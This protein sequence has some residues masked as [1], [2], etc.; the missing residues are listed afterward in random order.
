MS[1]RV[2]IVGGGLAGSEAAW[3]I[4]E[5]GFGVDLY[6]MRPVRGTDAHRTERL[7]ELVCSNS[8]RNA[9][10]ETA[11]GCLK[12]EMRRLGSLVLAVADRTTVPAGAC[13]AVDRNLFAEGVTRA[14][15]EHPNVRLHRRELEAI[16]DGVAILATGP[17]TSPALSSALERFFGEA[18][19]YFYDAIAPIVAS[20]SIDM[21]IAYKASRY[22][23]GGD[24]YV[25]CPMTRDEYYAFVDAVLAAEKVPAKQFE[26]T[27]YFEGCMPIEEMA[28][29]GRD[30]LAFGPMRPVGLIDPRTGARPF[31]VVQLRQDDVE[32]RLFNMVG[33]QTKMTYPE[34]RR[35]FRMIPGL[36]AAE[37]VRLGS[38]HRNTFVDS[39]NVLM[40]TLQLRA[41]RTTFLAGQIIGVEGYVESAAAGLLAGINAARLLAGAPLVSPPATTA[42]GSLLAYVTQRGRRDFQPMNANYGLFPPLAGRARG[43]EKKL[44]LAE[45]ALADFDRWSIAG[46][47][48]STARR[49]P[50]RSPADV[51]PAASS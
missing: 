41:A 32:G 15:I 18:H 35:V 49:R 33:F 31:A 46:G 12:E 22:G 11:V 51:L 8:F 5:R 34:Q 10:L 44:Q 29:R 17:L 3:Q 45:R 2:T 20:D 30:T 25:N 47:L 40:P 16:P 19:L 6:E 38:L 39:P 21:T 26:R 23:K 13:L 37:F 50:E 42:L 28:R 24:D 43:R 1:E 27:V 4:A 36:A 9:S 14:V 7:A 48:A